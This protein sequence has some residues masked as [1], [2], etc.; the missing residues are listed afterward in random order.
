MLFA[1]KDMIISFVAID[2][3]ALIVLIILICYVYNK[4]KINRDQESSKWTSLFKVCF[5]LFLSTFFN[6]YICNASK[7]AIDRYSTDLIQAHYGMI[8]MPVFVINLLSNCIY[9][10]HL[11][12]L[13][14]YW[15]EGMLDELWRFVRRQM[16]YVFGICIVVIIGGKL[17]GI[18]ILSWFY[19]S[20]L[21]QY[22]IPFVILLLGGGLTALVDFLNNIITV[23]RKQRILIWI[24]GFICVLSAVLANALVKQYGMFGA[25]VA[26]VMPLLAQ[27]VIMTI[28]VMINIRLKRSE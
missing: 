12:E 14:N 26:Y 22:T 18:Q 5:P 28:Y 25:S 3:F 9:R 11:V 7:Y 1:T 20:E 21:S 16:L 19:A 23:I 15:N 2:I 17:V 8:F 6:I 27:A 13:A 10:P 24:Y 4:V